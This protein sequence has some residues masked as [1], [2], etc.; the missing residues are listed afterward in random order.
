VVIA[1][2]NSKGGVG[3]TTTSVNLAAALAARDRRVLLVDLDSQASASCWSGIKRSRL[4]PSSASCLLH[5]YPVLQAIRRTR[6]PHLDLITASQELANA[7]VALCDKPGR[8][9]ALK[10]MLA[11]VREQYGVIVLDCPPGLSL[12]TINSLV[13]ADGL[14]IPIVPR[15]LVVETLPELIAALE[16]VRSRLGGKARVLGLLLMMVNNR[17][18]GER[19]I[20]Q[21]IRSQYRERVF[22]TEI[23]LSSVFEDAPATGKSVL[24]FAP[25][26]NAA[27]S[28][29]RLASEVLQRASVRH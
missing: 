1:V 26:S 18:T 7:D 27:E 17:R 12:L 29:R 11:S 15:H 13:A 9:L 3:K 19:T 21:R 4:K 8:E 25:R 23:P 20:S 16:K 24:A 10:Q 14:I 28:F 5:D 6:S 2:V 22:I